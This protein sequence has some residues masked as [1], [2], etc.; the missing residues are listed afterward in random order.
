[1]GRTGRRL[2]LGSSLGLLIAGPAYA[3]TAYEDQVCQGAPCY[4]PYAR[5]ADTAR[6][7]AGVEVPLNAA[8]DVSVSTA[9]DAGSVT[10]D[11]AT[12]AVIADATTGCRQAGLHAATCTPDPTL[13]SSG[14][15]YAFF[16]VDIDLGGGND[17]YSV[18]SPSAVPIAVTD[19]AGDDV[20]TGGPGRDGFTL[21]DGN[22]FASTGDGDD[23][24]DLFGR[25]GSDVAM[26]GA[27]D[28]RA[29]VSTTGDAHLAMGAGNDQVSVGEEGH[30]TID[31]GDGDDSAFVSSS[32][33]NLRIACGAG[34]DHVYI[35]GSGTPDLAAD[36]ETVTRNP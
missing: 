27:G 24:V 13:A 5:Y 32:G 33:Q 28:D 8:N 26:T 3:G 16:A 31:L 25:T 20:L 4:G 17:R 6:T 22:D 18:G 29:L 12:Q 36:C 10:I 19:G 2:L 35:D 14:P 9:P 1:M 7:A 34:A 15:P 11:D 30:V 23:E 21:L